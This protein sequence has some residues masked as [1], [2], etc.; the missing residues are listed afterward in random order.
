[1]RATALHA[2]QRL[3]DAYCSTP[4][5]AFDLISIG[6]SEPAVLLTAIVTNGTTAFLIIMT[7]TFGVIFP[8]MLFER[9]LPSPHDEARSFNVPQRCPRIA[10]SRAV[11]GGNRAGPGKT[12]VDP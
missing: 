12:S 9:L 7:M 1:L 8:R 3:R 4:R 2:C 10:G 5:P 11:S 6:P